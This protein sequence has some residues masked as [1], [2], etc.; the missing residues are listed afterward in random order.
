MKTRDLLYGNEAIARGAADAGIS[1]AS[2]YPGTPS[3]EIIEFLVGFFPGHAEW[4][5]NE[6]IA[7]ET[8]LGASWAGRRALCT[9]KHVGLNVAADPLMTASYLG[10]RGGL[11]IAVADDPGAH[12]SQNEQ[13]SRHYAA[14]SGLP[15]LEPADPGEA[16]EMT[17][18]GFDLSEETGLPV[19]LRTM[20]RVSHSLGLVARREPR[21]ENPVSLEKN[22]R[23]MIAV[24]ANALAGHRALLEKQA[25]IRRWIDRSGF[26]GLAREGEG[27]RGIIACGSAIKYAL[28]HSGWP[29]LRIGAYPFGEEAI[30]SFAG[31]MDELWVLE[32]GDPVLEALA[33]RLHPAVK[34]K[35]SGDIDPVGE[36]DPAAVRDAL[37]GRTGRD[38]PA[39]PP[40]PLP[41]RPPVMCP[42]CSHRE[43][44]LS[45]KEAGPAFTTGDI[46]CYTLGAAPP[47]SALDTCLCMGASISQAAGIAA[48]GVKRVAAVIGDST[49][50][51]SGITALASAV[52]NRADILVLVLDNDTVGM[53]GHQPTPLIGIDARGRETPRLSLE[54]ICRACGAASVSVIDPF[55][56]DETRA[57]I[58]EKLD[59][60]G[61][62]V[63]ISRRA[64]VLAARRGRRK[65]GHRDDSP[66]AA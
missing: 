39:S 2:G 17:R 4:A 40:V 32:E 27:R 46:G 22:P 34:G 13:D 43:L 63:I 55:R 60:P 52:Y 30:A 51:H 57:L 50:L 26:N 64:C 6:K 66:E 12:S 7:L 20:T 23:R 53:T 31:R 29:V 59:A 58:G 61:V 3:T 24:P 38:A 9:T 56:R 54:D 48:Q 33:R 65:T 18:A 15:C 1:L 14:F 21:P 8:A 62:N 11:V 42:G 28:E 5:L 36:L 35:M 10:W 37:A 47:L 19:L 45:L 44:Y 41:A 49:F 25:A 16:Y